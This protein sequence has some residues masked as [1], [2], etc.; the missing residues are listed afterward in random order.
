M[1]GI[2]AALLRTDGEAVAEF[3][4]AITL[5]YDPALKQRI[6]GV[7]GG[8]GPVMAV[9]QAVTEAH[10]QA[11]AALLAKAGLPPAEIA[12]LG[13][14]GHTILHRPDQRRT[15]QIGDGVLL[16][17]LTGIATVSDFRSQDVAAGGQGAPLVPLYHAALSRKAGLAPPLLVLNLGGVGNVTYI[18]GSDADL[19]AFDTGPGNALLDDWMLRH[20]QH[21]QDEG[22]ATAAKGRVDEERLARLLAHPYFAARPPKSLD[23]DDFTA[24][25]VNGLSLEDGA[26]TLTAFTAAAVARGLAHLPQRPLRCLVT[27]GGRHNATMM[28]LLTQY[29]NLPVEAVEAVGWRG[30]SLEA[31]A[32]AFLAMRAVRGL[33]LS[34]PGTTGVRSAI[35][36]GRLYRP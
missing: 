34:L 7:L 3:G 1:D 4:P 29:L 5:S 23:R 35:S 18:G 15:W 13:F 24:D 6:R 21:A 25:A 14:H 9:S 28:R 12:W 19:I 17:K 27:G 36:G 8:K 31:E 32:F 26:A 33:S 16:A 20:V 11:V 22:G 10:A 30:D 2:D